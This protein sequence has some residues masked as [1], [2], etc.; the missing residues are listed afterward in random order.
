METAD[1][2]CGDQPTANVAVTVSEQ[3]PGDDNAA[4]AAVARTTIDAHGNYRRRA[5]QVRRY[6]RGGHI[7]RDC[8]KPA[9]RGDKYIA[10]HPL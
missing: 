4:G 3:I 6:G 7:R 10:R 9:D 2:R 8:R 1:E 5:R